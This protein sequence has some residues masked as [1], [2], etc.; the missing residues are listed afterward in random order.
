MIKD[1]FMSLTIELDDLY[2]ECANLCIRGT[3]WDPANEQLCRLRRDA[4][5]DCHIAIGGREIVDNLKKE[6]MFAKLQSNG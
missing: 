5:C 4:M 3:V 1:S 2:M 6:I